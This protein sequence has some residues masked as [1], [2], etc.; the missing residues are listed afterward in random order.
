MNA[1]FNKFVYSYMTLNRFI[2]QFDNVLRKKV[3]VE[4]K[5]SLIP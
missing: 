3:E 1:F 2:D 4:T 5:A